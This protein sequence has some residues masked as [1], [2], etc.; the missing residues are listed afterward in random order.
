MGNTQYTK[1]PAPTIQREIP[2]IAETCH[3]NQSDINQLLSELESRLEPIMTESPYP[4]D[5][6][7]TSRNTELGRSLEL[8]SEKQLNTIYR[9][10]RIIDNI[11]I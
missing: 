11:E 2:I 10:R 7:T 8:L 1:N 9:L 5:G 6:L 4:D 3:R